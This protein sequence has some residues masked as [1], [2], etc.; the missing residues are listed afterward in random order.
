MELAALVRLDGVLE[1]LEGI[2]QMATDVVTQSGNRMGNGIV[3]GS[4]ARDARPKKMPDAA[5]GF[6]VIFAVGFVVFFLIALLAQMSA[7]HWRPWLPGSEG[8]RSLIGDVKSA[9]YTFMSY[10]E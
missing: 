2:A 7:R 3:V 10:L 9:V 8:E 1:L 6:Q 5:R 4:F